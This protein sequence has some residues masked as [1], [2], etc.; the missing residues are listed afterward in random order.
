MNAITPETEPSR[1]AENVLCHGF[2]GR[3]ETEEK[4]KR[5]IRETFIHTVVFGLSANTVETRQ[6]NKDDVVNNN[7]QQQQQANKSQM[8]NTSRDDVRLTC[9]ERA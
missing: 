4:R 2:S 5:Q 1:L 3:V 9:T 6:R 8:T 7:N